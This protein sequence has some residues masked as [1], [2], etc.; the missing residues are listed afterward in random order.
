MAGA[1]IVVSHAGAGSALSALRAGRMPLIA[2]RRAALGEAGDDHQQELADELMRRG[3]AHTEGAE[4]VTLDGLLHVFG[5][6]V[7][8][9]AL[10]PAFEVRS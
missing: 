4:V 10:P 8:Q 3:L 7:G 6:S 5:A 2:S 9:S 1:D